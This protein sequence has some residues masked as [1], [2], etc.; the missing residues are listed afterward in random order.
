[1]GSGSQ[2]PASNLPYGGGNDT[3][4]GNNH[5]SLPSRDNGDRSNDPFN[6]RNSSNNTAGWPTSSNSRSHSSSPNNRTSGADTNGMS[7]MNSQFAQ[8]RASDNSTAYSRHHGM[9][10][11]EDM[12]YSMGYGNTGGSASRQEPSFGASHA[13][14]SSFPS[15]QEM[16]S[17]A[18]Q[19]NQQTVSQHQAL[20]QQAFNL[21]NAQGLDEQPVQLQHLSNGRISSSQLNPA[22]QTWNHN[23]PTHA[24][25]GS[26]GG[27]V[28][29][30]SIL[31]HQD[32]LP[33]ITRMDQSS[34]SGTFTPLSSTWSPRESGSRSLENETDRR[35]PGQS[36]YPSYLPRLYG[37]YSVPQGTYTGTGYVPSLAPTAA[38]IPQFYQ[39][40]SFGNI[41]VNTHRNQNQ[42]GNQN[43]HVNQ[44]QYGASK[45]PWCIKF[46][47]LLKSDK[48]PH[49]GL[50]S[51]FGFVVIASGDQDISRFIQSKLSTAKSDEKEKMFIEI[52]P[53]MLGLMKDLYGNYVCQRLIEH[54]SMAQ[55]MGV[56][57]TVRGHILELSLNAFGCRVFQKIVDCCPVSHIAGILDEIH[58]YEIL[59]VLMQDESGNHVIQKL[60]QT[61][62]P[63]DVR[64]I[65]V[66]CQENARELS[67]NQYSC[68]ILQRVLEYAEEDDKKKLVQKLSLMMDKLITDPW[69][70]YVA[71]H[72][73]QHR[74]PEDR[75]PIFEHV[76]SRLFALCQHKL[77]SHVVE[78]CIMY[79]TPEQR[80]QIRERL[81]PVND[82]EKTL[83]NMLKDQFG[84]YVIASL[85]RN[86]EWGSEERA[87]FKAQIRAQ[88]DLL[89]GANSRTFEKIEE[90]FTNDKK[91]EDRE[92][93]QVEVNSAGPTPV[94]TNETNSPQSDSL[95][96]ADASAMEVHP[97]DDKNTEA[98]PR[99]RDD[100]D[101]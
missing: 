42:Y 82:T 100:D 41:G 2:P 52:G 99:V 46:N 48:K 54:G 22:S 17:Y 98:N 30:S 28:D 50:E 75:D 33:A 70:N 1:M 40:S 27:S 6:T 90:I 37:T 49:L 97:T 9:G 95:A 55:K 87:Q 93:L 68:R 25:S 16:R 92:R 34:S 94:L 3:I 77:A 21:N 29:L 44:N 45:H 81:S 83:E 76:M 79:G 11:S 74:G 63:K 72:I 86:L 64:F 53:D 38:S 65:T 8:L 71:G 5:R 89:K 24:I 69:G 7:F 43:Q 19:I 57:E 32:R 51:I 20:N 78:K 31:H 66:A 58:S 15:Q 47:S 56:V 61:M 13:P 80:T 10:N 101:A 60:V 91:R 62:P 67:A 14:S 39:G 96:S 73:I 18:Q 12:M 23:M 85:L 36:Q 35:M 26:L 88:V 4:W 59:K 84:N